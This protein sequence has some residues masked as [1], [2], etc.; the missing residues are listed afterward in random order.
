MLVNNLYLVFDFYPSDW[1]ASPSI[2]FLISDAG[3]L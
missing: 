3:T 1:N 2:S